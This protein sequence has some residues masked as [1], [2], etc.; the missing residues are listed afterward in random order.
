MLQVFMIQL[1]CLRKRH[2]KKR[3]HKKNATVYKTFKIMLAFFMMAFFTMVFFMM[4]FF[5]MAFSEYNHSISFTSFHKQFV[6][7]FEWPLSFFYITYILSHN[8]RHVS[9]F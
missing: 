4:A 7:S 3:D 6:K 5:T 1:M 2:R 9:V 8:N